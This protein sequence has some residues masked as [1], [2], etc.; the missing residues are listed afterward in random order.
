MTDPSPFETGFPQVDI[1]ACDGSPVT[2][3]PWREAFR[4]AE[5]ARLAERIP[6][7]GGLFVDGERLA[8]YLIDLDTREKARPILEDFLR[9]S[10]PHLA[11]QADDIR[12]LQGRYDWRQLVVWRS[13][14]D[15]RLFQVEGIVSGDIDES[16]N[17]LA[18]GYQSE[19][20][21]GAA[22]AELA[23][24]SVPR[25]AVILE[26]RA[27]VCTLALRASIVVEVRDAVGE[28]AAI[29]ATVTA[30]APG[31]E[32]TIEGFGDPLRIPVLA[33][34]RGGVFEV[35]VS[36]PW[37]EEAVIPQVVVPEGP[38]GV[39]ETPVVQVTVPLAP[40]APPVRQV[41]LPS[42]TYAFGA[43]ICGTTHDLPAWVV[44]DPGVSQELLWVSRNPGVVTVEPGGTSPDGYRIGRITPVCGGLGS[45][46][47]VAAS[48]V[49]PSVRDSTLVEVFQ[50]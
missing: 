10:F 23:R 9:G 43:S 13:C 3:S 2:G 46:W 29:G 37:H 12:W 39:T 34:N 19:E 18:Y 38:C 17:R 15:D 33:E 31:F 27:P 32:T 7:F 35:R 25:D 6:G 26:L 24:T 45:T 21:I 16:R 14:L 40:D 4:D 49:D 28:P 20:A 5:F 36:K 1:V 8:V 30:Q 22:E 42:D 44:T 50:F 48:A 11:D 47:V 41:V